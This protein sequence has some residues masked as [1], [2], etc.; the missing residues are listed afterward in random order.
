MI[1][2]KIKQLRESVGW[3]QSYL[4]KEAGITSAAI[5]MIEKGGREPTLSLLQKIANALGVSITCFLNLENIKENNEKLFF[6]EFKILDKLSVKD[7]QLI[8]DIAKRLAG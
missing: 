3:S 7:K 4:A 2:K 6:R 8:L 5:S 1:Y